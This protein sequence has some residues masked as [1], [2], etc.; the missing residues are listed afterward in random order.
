MDHHANGEC[1]GNEAGIV[2]PTFENRSSPTMVSL[3]ATGWCFRRFN[4]GFRAT[5]LWNWS[6]SISGRIILPSLTISYPS[7][8]NGFLWPCDCDSSRW[9]GSL[10]IRSRSWV[11]LGET[12]Y[13]FSFV[14][15]TWFPVFLNVVHMSLRCH[16]ALF[17]SQRV[18]WLGR[19][20]IV[21]LSIDMGGS[22]AFSHPSSVL[23][24]SF[25]SLYFRFHSNFTNWSL[26]ESP[27]QREA[28]KSSQILVLQACSRSYGF[29]RF[30]L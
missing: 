17:L 25:D 21:R 5:H 6:R 1:L 16:L 26:S 13:L 30:F 24:L 23:Y 2:A 3:N 11:G 22:P 20:T 4:G 8:L 9:N 10:A 14:T 28:N 18:R 7:A 19:S 29:R 15:V 12:Q 27:R